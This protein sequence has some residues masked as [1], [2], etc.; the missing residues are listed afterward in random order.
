MVKLYQK[1]HRAITSLEWFTTRDW[2][3]S[4]NNFLM[5]NDQLDEKD[6]KVL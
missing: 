1:L 6:K 3:F 4:S 2:K 5:L